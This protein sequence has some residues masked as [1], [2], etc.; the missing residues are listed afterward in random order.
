MKTRNFKQA[1]HS[2][3]KVALSEYEKLSNL[4]EDVRMEKMEIVGTTLYFINYRY[5][6]K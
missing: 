6:I 3:L 5:P 4:Y 2:E 1:V